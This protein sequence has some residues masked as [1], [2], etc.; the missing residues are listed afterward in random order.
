MEIAKE[1]FLS[2]RT[3]DGYRENMFAKFNVKI[4]SGCSLVCD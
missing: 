4:K 3:I 1:M 2:P